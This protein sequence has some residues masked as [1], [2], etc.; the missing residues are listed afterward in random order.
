MQDMGI[1]VDTGGHTGERTSL[2]VIR[3][4]RRPVVCTH[5]NMLGLNDN[6]RNISDRVI[7]GI[8]KTGGLVGI[9]AMEGFMTWSRKD[10]PRAMTGPFPPRAN[11][12]RYVDEFDYMKRLVGVDHV[13]LGTDFIS[14][15]ERIDPSKEFQFPPEM[16][17]NQTP[18]L[19]L[20]EGFR[21]C[22]GHRQR[23]RRN[24]TSWLLRRRDRENLRW[25][26]DACV[27]RSLELLQLSA[28]NEGGRHA[29]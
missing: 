4:A 29:D 21:K 10:A 19:K 24:G 23:P 14:D 26:L 18:T 15:L 1:L 3:M 28:V 5:A 17:Y 9:T 8:A 13:A 6:P 2:D 7:E 22:F 12:S 25:Q 11:V 20:V 27:P 16:T